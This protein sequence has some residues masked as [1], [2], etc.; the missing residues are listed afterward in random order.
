[1]DRKRATCIGSLLTSAVRELP[2]TK[3]AVTVTTSLLP[4]VFD[5]LSRYGKDPAI[6]PVVVAAIAKLNFSGCTDD[7]TLG[8]LL[9]C[10]CCR[11]DVTASGLTT[12]CHIFDVF[13]TQTSKA[14]PFAPSTH[15]RAGML[16]LLVDAMGQ[17]FENGSTLTQEE[18]QV[19][20]AAAICFSSVLFDVDRNDELFTSH[21]RTL[22]LLCTVP[23]TV[24]MAAI[25]TNERFHDLMRGILFIFAAPR[26]FAKRPVVLE[27]V[28]NVIL[29]LANHV[30]R[31]KMDH[32]LAYVIVYDMVCFI[33]PM[34]VDEFFIFHDPDD[35]SI[36][37][38]ANLLLAL[39]R[40]QVGSNDFGR[41]ITS[42]CRILEYLTRMSTLTV[43]VAPPVLHAPS[44][45]AMRFLLY[46][47]ASLPTNTTLIFRNLLRVLAHKQFVTRDMCLDVAEIVLRCLEDCPVACMEMCREQGLLT[48]LIR[49]ATI[50]VKNLD[51]LTASINALMCVI[52]NGDAVMVAKCLRAVFMT[53]PTNVY[54]RAFW[55][56]LHTKCAAASRKHAR[57]YGS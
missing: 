42:S 35:D 43:D 13:N 7:I 36:Y 38:I 25:A 28:A 32:K 34:H 33:L 37:P 41:R 10:L 6:G 12:A 48:M 16:M 51:V 50:N 26:E 24:F 15:S 53:M 44:I 54:T 1:M 56:L 45:S 30:N 19:L 22:R 5:V 29:L 14:A 52:V 18:V 20:V 8:R 11:M 47:G 3:H 21:T 23:E 57:P 17:H 31:I 39:I 2:M 9:Y 27:C 55:V 46:D 4:A 40:A 49:I